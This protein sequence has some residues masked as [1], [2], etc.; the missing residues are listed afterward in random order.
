MEQALLHTFFYCLNDPAGRLEYLERSLESKFVVGGYMILSRPLALR[1]PYR[2]SV[3]AGGNRLSNV[4]TMNT[5]PLGKN[6]L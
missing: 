6:V 1:F 5:I 2:A 4:P 3:Y